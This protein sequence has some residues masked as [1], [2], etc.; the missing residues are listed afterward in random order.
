M[1][2]K[3]VDVCVYCG[4]GVVGEYVDKAKLEVTHTNGLEKRDIRGI[5]YCHT[6]GDIIFIHYEIEAWRF[7]DK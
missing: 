6:C 4:S 5:F 3:F 7:I 1:T 2:K